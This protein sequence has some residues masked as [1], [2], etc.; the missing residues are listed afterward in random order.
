[1]R[2][3]GDTGRVSREEQK[4]LFEVAKAGRKKQSP[5][6]WFPFVA[7]GPPLHEAGQRGLTLRQR[8]ACDRELSPPSAVPSGHVH[9]RLQNRLLCYLG[10]V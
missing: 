7:E 5:L 6:T 4:R 9:T 3:R 1:M 2:C 8:S 10:R